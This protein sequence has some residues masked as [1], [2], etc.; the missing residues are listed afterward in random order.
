MEDV[1]PTFRAHRLDV[2]KFGE[3]SVKASEAKN[4]YDRFDK[5]RESLA[6]SRTP[7]EYLAALEMLSESGATPASFRKSPKR[8]KP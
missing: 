1:S 3:I 4:R 6:A 7:S 5:L 2:E 8:Q